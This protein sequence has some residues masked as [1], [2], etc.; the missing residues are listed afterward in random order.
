MS[1][2]V[3]ELL[4]DRMNNRK[5]GVTALE[6]WGLGQDELTSVAK[7]VESCYHYKRSPRDPTRIP[8]P[9]PLAMMVAKQYHVQNLDEQQWIEEGRLYLFS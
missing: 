6:G 2:R 5:K 9:P 7:W 1:E 8:P 3:Y 4:I